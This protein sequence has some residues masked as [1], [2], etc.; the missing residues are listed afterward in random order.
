M[1][2]E[3]AHLGEKCHGRVAE[4][5]RRRRPARLTGTALAL[6]A[7]ACVVAALGILASP[8]RA[9]GASRAPGGPA[10]V[11]PA[12]PDRA[13]VARHI[14]R[15]AT[16]EATA[17]VPVAEAKAKGGCPYSKENMAMEGA[18][19]AAEGGLIPGERYIA[20]NRFRVKEGAEAQFEQRWATRKSSLMKLKGFRWFG[21]MQRVPP[22]GEGAAPYEDDYSYVSFTIWETKKNFE[23]WRKGPAFKEA[24]GGGGPMQFF[25][26]IIN[27]F[28]TNNGPPKPAFWSGMLMEKTTEEKPRLM[29]GPG[30]RPDFDGE[31]VLEPEVFVSMNRFTVAE[32]REKE[33]EQRWATR[34]SKL[35]GLPGFRF[36]QLMRRDQTP[37]DDVNY[38]SAAVWDDRASFE[39]WRDGEG[40]KKAHG[41]GKKAE[42]GHG[43]G[44]GGGPMGGVLTRAPV[45][46]FYEGKLVLESELGA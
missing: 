14:L 41:G 42:G 38:I 28:M 2:A 21:L 32:G 3:R 19:D 40:F 9:E 33:F 13:A 11:N 27:G 31:Q 16:E 29:G 18:P 6:I 30:G 8:E 22:S 5:I 23:S 7:A 4:K 10:F 26:M 12:A 37:D 25:S 36:F 39:N 45:P 46:Y 17:A 15:R 20:M 24:H 44:G 1:F 34:E 35:Q 43:S